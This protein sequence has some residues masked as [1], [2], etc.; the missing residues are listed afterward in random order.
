MTPE[1][2]KNNELDSLLRHALISHD[3]LTIPSGLSEKTIRKLGKRAILR[4]LLLEL[5]LKAGVVLASLVILT[6][7]F[8]LINGSGVLDSLF[9]RLTDNRQMVTLLLLAGSITVLIDQ[10]G[11]RFYNELKK[12]PV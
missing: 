6:G 10:V 1:S 7:I 11:L 5:S 12:D 2:I 3:Q 8:I 9:T 4:S